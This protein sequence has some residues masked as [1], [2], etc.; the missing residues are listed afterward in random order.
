[1]NGDGAQDLI[2]G[3]GTNPC[4]PVPTAVL[5]NDGHGRFPTLTR[6][7]QAPY[8]FDS[9]IDIQAGDLNGD[10]A[11]DLVLGYNKQSFT[12]L[13]LQILIN[14]GHGNFTDETAQRLPPQSDNSF[15]GFYNWIRLIDLNGD[16]HLDIA[17]GLETGGTHTSPYFLN[18]GTGVFAPLPDNLGQH[19]NDTYTL[20]EL[21][22]GRGLDMVF[23]ESSIY[24]ARTTKPRDRLYVTLGPGNYFSF[25]GE[26]GRSIR[27]V[28]PGDYTLVV[29]DRS[30]TRV[31][32]IKGPSADLSSRDGIGV[33]YWDLLFRAGQKYAF[34][35]TAPA[36][37]GR[38]RVTKR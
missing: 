12:G 1:V 29:W 21:G 9:P 38:I 19:P 35:V 2:V 28:R 26:S 8:G 18:D 15:G 11:P 32:R 10:G 36:R 23:G 5:L 31:F 3:G 22:G 25:T 17:T 33:V 37:H 14:D 34:T 16:G 4:Q 13:W 20:A 27:S 24:V 30:P 6:L 7:P